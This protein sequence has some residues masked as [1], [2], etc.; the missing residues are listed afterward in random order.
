LWTARSVLSDDGILVIDHW[1]RHG[2][3]RYVGALQM[4]ARYVADEEFE[5][6]LA[7]AGFTI[8]EKRTTANGVVVVYRARQST[9]IG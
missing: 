7:A 2:G 6:A 4:P 1:R 9:R 3:S 8:E 5:S